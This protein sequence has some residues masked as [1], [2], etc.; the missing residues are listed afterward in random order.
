MALFSFGDI[1]FKTS[2]RQGFGPTG[3]LL[4][5]KYGYDI[6]RYPIDLGNYDKGHYMVIHVNEQVKTQFESRAVNNGDLP[7][8]FQNRRDNGTATLGSNFYD[9]S[10]AL[11]S[12]ITSIFPG[13]GSA[14]DAATDIINPV[15]DQTL[16]LGF[17]RTIRRTSDTIALYMPDTLNFVHNQ[18]YSEAGLGKSGLSLALAGGASI[19]DAIKNS[20]NDVKGMLSSLGR[21]ATPFINAAVGLLAERGDLTRTGFAAVTG[22][23][24]NPM[25]E[26]L[27]T[28]PAFRE[29]RFDFMLYARNEEEGQEIHRILDRLKYHQA[30]EFNTATNGFLMVPPSEFDIKFYYNGKENPNIPKIS[31]CVL[32]SI[33]IDYAP[34]GFSAYEVPKVN[35][36]SIGG[37]GMPV[38]IRLSL[39]FKETEYLTKANYGK[40]SSSNPGELRT[41]AE[42]EASRSLGDFPG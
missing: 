12:G 29:F 15:D 19:V 26:M 39:N 38:A 7:T 6:L 14:F 18:Q 2:T 3:N 22:T 40:S 33:D 13:L 34:N 41:R 1:Q 4:G 17:A 32:N 31:T 23:V 20:P 30:P 25:L 8:I 9:I 36:P 42:I 35:V 5:G 24:L 10:S 37:T 27:F 11:R 16:R 21:N 28:S